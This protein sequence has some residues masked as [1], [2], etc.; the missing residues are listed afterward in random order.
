MHII[1]EIK[2]L[3]EK[4]KDST[5]ACRVYDTLRRIHGDACDT[6]NRKHSKWRL[7]ARQRLEA[8][9][10]HMIRK[11]GDD[12]V[13]GKFIKKIARA[14]KD[15]FRFVLDPNIPS[16][17]NAAERGLRE[18]VVHRK[19][20]GCIRSNKTMEWLGNLFSCV[21]TWKNRHLDRMAELMHYI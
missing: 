16:T 8:R 19:I 20:R 11:Y 18:I 9:V 3:S 2:D 12:P 7:A 5:E 21:T 1:R 15:L 10:S 4:N 6:K 14:K 17:N 13:V